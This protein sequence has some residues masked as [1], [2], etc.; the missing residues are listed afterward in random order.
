MW[1]LRHRGYNTDGQRTGLLLPPLP[2]FNSH[3][4]I[5]ANDH[6][7]P[8]INADHLPILILYGNPISPSFAPLYLALHALADP[9]TGQP[10]IQLA[11]RWKPATSHSSEKEAKLALSGY[12]TL[13]DIKKVD[14]IAID[15]RAK[16]AGW[17]EDAVA[18]TAGEGSRIY[19]ISGDD[20][21]SKC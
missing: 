14:Y 12:G 19:P 18:E 15:D 6:L 20:L 8:P 13:L 1:D 9:P 4:P 16:K 10:R 3:P 2:S 21:S 7:I 17:A 5:Y 11:L